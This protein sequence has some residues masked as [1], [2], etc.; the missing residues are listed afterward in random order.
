MFTESVKLPA[1]YSD[2][3]AC[4]QGAL[5]DRGAISSPIFFHAAVLRGENYFSLFTTRSF[6]KHDLQIAKDI[7]RG[8]RE[9]IKNYVW[10]R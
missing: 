7:I 4:F 2:R 8:Q 5:R 3:Q 1:V 10:R 9:N 6:F